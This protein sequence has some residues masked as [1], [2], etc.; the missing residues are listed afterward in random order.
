M[1][2]TNQTSRV[3]RASTAKTETDPFRT[4]H[5]P[6][7]GRST[8]IRYVLGPQ[9]KIGVLA[10]PTRRVDATASARPPHNGSPP[11]SSPRIPEEASYP[12]KSEP[13]ALQACLVDIGV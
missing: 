12:K 5:V 2:G 6:A 8:I 3:T 7:C 10:I 13:L 11:L 9:I 4:Q 1:A